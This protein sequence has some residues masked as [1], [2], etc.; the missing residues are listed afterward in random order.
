M[1]AQRLV[2]PQL[3]HVGDQRRKQ[4]AASVLQE[5]QHDGEK[6]PMIENVLLMA[7]LMALGAG[8]T[9]A[10]LCGFIYWMEFQND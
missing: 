9:A 1:V 10:L 8:V 4:I 6:N 3:G 2:P 5:V 7:L